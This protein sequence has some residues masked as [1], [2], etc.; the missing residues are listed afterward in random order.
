[1]KRIALVFF[2]AI[3]LPS[4][5]LAV[6]AFRSVRDQSLVLNSQRALFYQSACDAV[7]AEITLFMDEVRVFHGQL[8]D[9]LVRRQ[10][11]GLVE[12]YAVAIT[13]SWSQ[14]ALGAVVDDRGNIITPRDGESAEADRFLAN[15]RDFLRNERTVE[16][17]QA[18]PVLNRD[19]AIIADVTEEPAGDTSAPYVSFL[20]SAAELPLA[21]EEA[22][23]SKLK[24]GVARN[25]L[26][27]QR[28]GAF[29]ESV[30][31]PVSAPVSAPE[32]LLDAAPPSATKAEVAEEP[33]LPAAATPRPAMQ[34]R[35]VMP[36]EAVP[37]LLA[38]G[39][40][41]TTALS[42]PVAA[43]GLSRL[44][45]AEVKSRDLTRAESGAVSRLIDG[46]LHILL[47]E[48]SPLLP[49]F[50][51][52]T[53]LDLSTIRED[54]E[55]L[56]SALPL[57]SRDAVSVALLDSEGS[58]VAQTEAGFTTDWS[59]PFVAAEVGQ[60]LPRW[61][62]AVY[63]LNPD[64]LNE[65]ATTLRWT[66]SLI[67]LSLLIAV[68]VGTLLVLK[69]VRYEM[70]LATRKTDFVSNVSHELKTPLTSIRMFSELLACGELADAEKTRHYSGIIHK[71]SGR[72]SRL[73]NRLLDFSRL[74]RDEMPLQS[75][76][77]P[78]KQLVRDCVET[79]RMQ[80][81]SGSIEI[82]IEEWSPEELVVTGDGDALEQ[83]VLNLLNNAE[84]YA[85]EGGEIR[86]ELDS[87]P[88]D[89][90]VLSVMD[91][92]KGIPRALREKVF[93]KFYRVDDSIHAGVEGSGIGLALC[94]QLVEKHGGEIR[95]EL[96]PG[97]GTAFVV[98]LPL[99][100]ET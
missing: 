94:R 50:T 46:E 60:I 70:Q 32:P 81:E 71:E 5:L 26:E 63:F 55:L 29:S 83:V 35:N 43:A 44:S 92:G 96:R 98:E 78:L 52:W 17:Y 10:N 93:E 2:L 68:V 79:Y 67:V 73:I 95:C 57:R 62:V 30:A 89:R 85:G 90:A 59:R 21:K 49:G 36:V 61:E 7:A 56:F 88:G 54:L 23:P 76:P 3:L 84:K 33:E 42:D 31:A 74:D 86:V 47:W 64:T 14:A 16:V 22:P 40:G 6:L 37:S 9:E 45:A 8:V 72:L 28:S 69:A 51:F 53:E 41:G 100:Q 19:L 75:E 87:V 58:P 91:R 25:R 1:M 39:S 77:V 18:P 4:I 20:R 48:K 13:D 65:T 12:T 38:E 97:G 15:H 82:A 99:R 80:L 24:V 27:T 66:L 11:S 34:Q